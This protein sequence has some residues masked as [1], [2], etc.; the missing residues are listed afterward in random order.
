M[1]NSI[2]I[3]LVLGLGLTLIAADAAA[4]RRTVRVDGGNGWTQFSIGS[5]GCPGTTAGVTAANTLVQLLGLTFSGRADTAYLF[6]DYCQV[7]QVGTLTSANY[8]YFDEADLR[9]LFGTNPGNAIT[10]IR[11]AFLDDNLFNS[12][13]GFQWGFYT[14]PG[15]VVVAELYGLESVTLDNTSYISGSVWNGQNGYSGEYFCFQNNV[16]I[17]SWTALTDR[18]SACLHALGVLFVN[19]FE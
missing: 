13:T 9:R 19:G 3:K 14:F 2:G 1:S 4:A 18:N 5:A 7:A 8:I 11:Y 15:N 17:G 6:N 16:Y 12:P 10:G